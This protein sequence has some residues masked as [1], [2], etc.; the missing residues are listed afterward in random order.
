[1][2]TSGF[3]FEVIAQRGKARAGVLHTPRGDIPTP[4]FMPVGTLGTVK[5]MTMAEVAASPIDAKIILGNTYHLYLRPGLEVISAHG[6]LHGFSAWSRPIL[7]DSGGF[8]V[9]SLAA[10]NKIDD[11]GVDFRSH[12]DGSLHRLTPERSMEIQGVL[13]SDI[14]MVFDQCPPA[15]ASDAGHEAAMAR[16]TAWAERCAKVARPPGQALFG[17]VQ[18]GVDLD[19]RARHLDQLRGLDFD[20]YALGGL[21]VGEDIE[22]MYDVL[23]GFAAELPNDRPRY[24]MGVGTPADLSRGVGAGIDMFDCV[25]PTRN[26]R[27]GSLFTSTGRLTISN[28][29][30]KSDT[31]PLDADCPCD[32][33]QTVSRA[34]LRHLYIAKEILY[35][36]LAT[37]HNLTFY[38]RHMARLRDAILA[39]G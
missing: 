37:M 27:N 9:F 39:S 36:R 28:A 19:R 13:G 29:C 3:S 20:G 26:A 10:I 21:S 16:T 2:T 11:D 5:A 17:I 38:A 25:M 14:A 31:S 24:L 32:T 12:I 1:M 8:Q 30:H 23:D 35:N 33:C 15:D 6:G 4:V 22:V 18:G 34:Y 7:T